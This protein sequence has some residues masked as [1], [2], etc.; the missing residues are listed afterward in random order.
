MCHV[1]PEYRQRRVSLPEAR[2][3]AAPLDRRRFLAGVAAAT[4]SLAARPT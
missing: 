4:V 1:V 3:P 2:A